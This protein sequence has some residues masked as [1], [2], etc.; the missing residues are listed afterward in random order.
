MEEIVGTL[1]DVTIHSFD[2]VYDLIFTSNRVIAAN[3]KHPE[4]T[5]L[6]YTWRTAF[7]GSALDRRDQNIE[8]ERLAEV[9][10]EVEKSSSPNEIMISNPRNFA[11]PHKQVVAV[12][13][14]RRFFE[15]QVL[16]TILDDKKNQRQIPFYIKKHHVPEAQRLTALIKK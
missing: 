6:T 8:L 13:V 7:L 4:D 1:P 14:K 3:I 2:I 10:R 5:P 11:I 9:R 15:W 16:F 12:E